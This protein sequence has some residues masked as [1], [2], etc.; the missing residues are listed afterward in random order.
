MQSK[1]IRSGLLAAV[2][3]FALAISVPSIVTA[4]QIAADAVADPKLAAKGVWDADTAYAVDD[5]VVARGSTWRALKNSTGR[6]PG[7]T[8]PNNNKY[9][10]LFARGFNPTGAWSSSTQYQADDLV[11]SN[12]STWRAKK[13][14]TNIAPV[15]GATW[16]QMASV[17]AAGAQGSQGPQGDTG[18]T[19]P[20][21]PNT[22]IG[23]GTQS[24][25][26]IS[27]N[28]D[29]NTGI[30]SPGPDRIAL[31]E[32]GALFLHNLGSSNIALGLSAL[33]AITGGT[34]NV[35]VGASSLF[36]NTGGTDNAAIGY[37]A[38]HDNINGGQNVAVGYLAMQKNTNGVRNTAVGYNALNAQ[39]GDTSYNT[40]LGSGTLLVTTTGSG[41]TAV[42]AEALPNNTEGASNVAVGQGAL[43]ANTTGGFN[44]ALGPSALVNKTTG[45]RNIGIGVSALPD[46]T[47]GQHNIAIG[48]QTGMG[49]TSGDD[50]IYIGGSIA[51]GAD[52]TGVIRIGLAGTQ[53]TFF[54]AGIAGVQA[55]DAPV[56][57]DS[58]T[59]Q[60][61]IGPAPSS[62]RFKYDIEAMADVSALLSK[63]QPVTYRYK[64]AK[65]D[66]SHPLQYGLI[67]ED[68]AELNPDL[69]MFDK[70]GRP[71]GVKYHLLPSFLLAGYQAQ[72]TTIAAQADEIA[73]LKERV[74]ATEALEA[75]LARL[76][77]ALPRVTKAAAR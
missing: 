77:A 40:A 4:Q 58:T 22:G 46:L 1:F 49:V 55:G 72:Q 65:A 73:R 23:A 21:G 52:E 34:H 50:N 61:G 53:T 35:A 14:N 36:S 48:D 24:A 31:V 64:Q 16:E 6:V 60:L 26:S 8:S 29:S 56:Y 71:N 67:A 44:V 38:L 27:F 30:Y 70:D 37:S 47:A 33:G 62:R 19:G 59:G 51:P 18:P 5:I 66:G 69:A 54:A 15:A 10:Q 20:A 76:E 39:S 2:S 45:D 74:A 28:G 57:V 9:W 42:G 13:T 7:S 41:N 12:G 17:G 3:V 32:G 25:P 68:V 63:L 11:T 43:G 75:R